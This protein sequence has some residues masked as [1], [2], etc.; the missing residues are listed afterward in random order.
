MKEW[1]DA[2]LQKN[3]KDLTARVDHSIHSVWYERNSNDPAQAPEQFIL[4]IISALNQ[5]NP[6]SVI[7]E[8]EQCKELI[9]KLVPKLR[10]A[11][12]RHRME[13]AMKMWSSAE[14]SNLANFASRCSEISIEVQAGFM[15]RGQIKTRRER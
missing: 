9:K 5:N 11:E 3:S 4:N 6:S 1:F 2:W 13:D 12:L 14:K 10:S 7:T 15:A 8:P